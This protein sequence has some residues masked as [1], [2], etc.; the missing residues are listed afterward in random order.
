MSTHKLYGSSYIFT[1]LF[2]MQYVRNFFFAL[3]ITSAIHH[4]L[5]SVCEHCRCEQHPS[6]Q[7][8]VQLWRL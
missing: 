4:L 7:L 8:S 1:Y 3:N 6:N 5:L 2:N